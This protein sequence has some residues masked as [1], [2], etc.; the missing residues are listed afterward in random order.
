MIDID[1]SKCYHTFIR[2]SENNI[3]G[4]SYALVSSSEQVSRIVTLTSRIVS[5]WSGTRKCLKYMYHMYGEDMGALK[6]Y[7]KHVDASYTHLIGQYGNQGVGWH[8][9]SVTIDETMPFQVC[10]NIYYILLSSLY[11]PNNS[12]DLTIRPIFTNVVSLMQK[13]MWSHDSFCSISIFSLCEKTV[14]ERK[15]VNNDVVASCWNI[16]M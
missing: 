11:F 8:P 14:F 10:F 1:Y 15:M 3:S 12:S 7:V 6:V 16:L 4:G 2:T 13:Q 5:N 9:S